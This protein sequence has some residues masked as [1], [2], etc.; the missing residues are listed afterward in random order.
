MAAAVPFIIAGTTALGVASTIKAGKEQKR[1]AAAQ[2][3]AER[4][5]ASN[6]RRQAIRRANQE[7]AR[8]LASAQALGASDFSAVAGGI[9]SAASR[10]SSAIGT[11]TQLSGLNA[12]A[13]SAAANANRLQSISGLSFGISNLFGGVGSLIP[14][15]QNKSPDLLG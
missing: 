12:I 2:A 9:G 3:R 15:K 7:R 5:R 14:Q 13:S 1:S 4:V 8:A 6:E 10:T 11:S